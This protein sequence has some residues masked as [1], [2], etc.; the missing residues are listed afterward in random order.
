VSAF[1]SPNGDPARD[2]DV[3]GALRAV[4][5]AIDR[6]PEAA[7][8]AA[9]AAIA[10]R[11]LDAELA[12]LT[13]E[14]GL[15]LSHLRGGQ[16]RLLAFRSAQMAIELEVFSIAG[17]ARLLGQLD[18]PLAADVTIESAAQSRNTRADSH[19]RFTVV[20]LNDSWMRVIVEHPDFEGARTAT[21]WFQA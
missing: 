11:D 5:A 1:D 17:V 6:V 9:K 13:S 4:L 2:D 15:E 14:S 10:W 12:L 7:L 3:E 18:P 20:G 16:P 19:G 8:A 21:E